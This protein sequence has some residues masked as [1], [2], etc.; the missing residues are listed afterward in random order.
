VKEQ[1]DAAK[2]AFDGTALAEFLFGPGGRQA[3]TVL[4]PLGGPGDDG[5]G[6]QSGVDPGD[7]AQAPLGS[8]Q[9]D[10]AR[11]HGVEAHGP[12][13]QRASEGGIMDIGAGEQK[14]EG[15]ARTATEQ[16]MHALAA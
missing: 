7:E 13:H 15:Q 6:M 1:E 8:V 14:E 5:G 16:G 3:G 9:A 11:A 2:E 4:L 12:F 10:N